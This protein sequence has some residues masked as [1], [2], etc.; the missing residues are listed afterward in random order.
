MFALSING[1]V[2]GLLLVAVLVMV[3]FVR[4]DIPEYA[5]FRALTDTASRQRTY[6]KWVVQSALLFGGGAILGLAMLQRLDAVIALPAEFRPLAALLPALAGHYQDFLIGVGGG[7]AGAG[8]A[9]FLAVRWRRKGAPGAKFKTLGD[10]E[11]LLPRNGAERVWALLIALNAGW[12]EELYFRILL[13]LLLT[14]AL[15]NAVAG[16]ALAIVA[17]GVVHLYQGV[18]G[19]LATAV[20]GAL[21]AALYLAT[22]NIWI[23]AAL[24]A[25]VDVNGLLLQPYL[26]RL[27]AQRTAQ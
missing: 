18:V 12:S 10:V 8:I 19:V 11:P 3:I 25:L 26:Q 15:G 27:G 17:F 22:C 16:F 21:F 20:L 9:A 4:N 1:M 5:R 13:P 7:A 24:H 14:L 23:A 2:W 6:R